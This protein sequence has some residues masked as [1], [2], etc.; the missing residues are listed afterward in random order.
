ME[1]TCL[2]REDLERT[3]VLALGL[4]YSDNLEGSI[5]HEVSRLEA[6]QLRKRKWLRQKG[7]D[8]HDFKHALRY[9]SMRSDFC[10]TTV[11]NLDWLLLKF[12]QIERKLAPLRVTNLEPKQ[13]LT[14]LKWIDCF[15]SP[16][17][18]CHLRVLSWYV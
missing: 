12:S 15:A 17:D 13:L 3:K 6:D 10:L 14:L 11:F 5:D 4:D 16:S 8:R 1:Y 18:G 7:D 2:L 9:L